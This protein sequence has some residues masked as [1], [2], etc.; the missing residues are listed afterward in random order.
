MEAALRQEVL[1]LDVPLIGHV[2]LPGREHL[3]WYAGVATFAALEIIEWPVALLMAGAKALSD[4]HHHAVLREFG[5][6]LEAGV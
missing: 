3:L 2:T 4:S 5:Q 6:A 1:T